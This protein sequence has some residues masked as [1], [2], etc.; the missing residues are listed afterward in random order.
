[1]RYTKAMH[2]LN[3]ATARLLAKVPF[4]VVQE[5]LQGVRVWQRLLDLCKS[6]DM[7]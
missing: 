5:E 2:K 7:L 6:T 1:M 3:A 4:A